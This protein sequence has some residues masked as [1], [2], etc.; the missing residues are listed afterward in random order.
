MGIEGFESLGFLGVGSF[1]DYK[2]W[3][4]GGYFQGSEIRV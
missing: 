1:W 3:D 4:L 2:T